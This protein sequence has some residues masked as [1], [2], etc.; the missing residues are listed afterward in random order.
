MEEKEKKKK[1]T[2]RIARLGVLT[3]L[4]MIFSYVESLIPLNFGIPG[5]KLGVANLVVVIALF[6]LPMG[7]AFLISMIR[8]LLL[9]ILFGNAASLLYSFTGA[10]FSFLVMCL[11]KRFLGLSVVGISVLGAVFHN[12]GQLFAAAYVLGNIRITYYLPV[13]LV[14]GILT[15][16]LIGLLAGE[17]KKRL[18][19]I[20]SFTR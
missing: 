8:V 20:E 17:I 2:E 4:A 11:S 16:L 1:L 14:A 5:I 3:A 9:G 18:G 13:L 19:R 10:V 12:I 15:G 6:F 7:D